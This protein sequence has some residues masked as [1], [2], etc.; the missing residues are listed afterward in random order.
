MSVAFKELAG[1]PTETIGPDGLKAERNVL[2]LW[3]DRFLLAQELLGDGYAFGTQGKAPYPLANAVV[4]MRVAMKPFDDV[5]SEQDECFDDIGEQINVFNNP[6]QALVRI[7]YELLTSGER[8]DLPE[9]EDDTFLTYRMDLGG[10]FMTKPGQSLKWEFGPEPPAEA[11]VP[12]EAVPT[13]RVSISE[14]HLSWSRVLNPP[15]N[16]IHESKGL[17]NAEV[18]MGYPPETMLFDGCSANKEF[19]QLDELLEPQFA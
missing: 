17:V 15:W 13:V 10:E 9:I 8:E 19:V 12:P 2:C 16:V 3:T 11:D 6:Q 14:H 5:P 18:F 4:A 7:S 1:S